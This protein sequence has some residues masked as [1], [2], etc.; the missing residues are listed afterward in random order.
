MEKPNIDYILKLS[1]DNEA[2]KKKLIDTLKYEL[3][4]DIDGYFVSLHLKKM[5]HTAEC[6]HKLKNKIGILGLEESY[7]LAESYEN[8]LRTGTNE[9][10]S[11]FEKILALIQ[12]FV[13]T[14]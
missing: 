13:N 10:Q 5:K 7:H 2:V 3:P 1:R 8:Q 11:E 4:L 6:V 14:L 12:N 9:L